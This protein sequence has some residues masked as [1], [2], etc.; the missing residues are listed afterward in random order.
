[1]KKLKTEKKE[2]AEA[3]TKKLSPAVGNHASITK[4]LQKLNHFTLTMLF[5]FMK[6]RK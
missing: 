3:I 5:I 2:M 1:M 4:D 6:T